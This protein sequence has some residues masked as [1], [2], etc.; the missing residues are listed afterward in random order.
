MVKE[1]NSRQKLQLT[2]EKKFDHSKWKFIAVV[3]CRPCSTISVAIVASHGAVILDTAIAKVVRQAWLKYIWIF[4]IQ[5]FSYNLVPGNIITWAEFLISSTRA[6]SE[7]KSTQQE[8]LFVQIATE[9]KNKSA[10]IVDESVLSRA[11]LI[12]DWFYTCGSTTYSVPHWNRCS[13][14]VRT[15]N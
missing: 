13:Q 8:T 12:K 6:Q 9:R 5:D 10:N 4:W 2:L 15:C 7:S 14:G 11:G 3:S 1:K